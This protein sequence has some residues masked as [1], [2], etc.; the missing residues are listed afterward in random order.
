MNPR[1]RTTH[2]VMAH[3]RRYQGFAATETGAP[4]VGGGGGG[5]AD[6]P[7][8]RCGGGGGEVGAPTW[9]PVSR[10]PEESRVPRPLTGTGEG[11]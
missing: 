3:Q 8:G 9:T 5:A 6:L 1:P 7:G 10:Y 11:P 4:G 2:S